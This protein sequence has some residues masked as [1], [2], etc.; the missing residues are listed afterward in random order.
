M[1]F[2]KLDKDK[3]VVPASSD[4]WCDF[5]NRFVNFTRF[6][7]G[8]EVSTVLLGIGSYLAREQFETMVFSSD[9]EIAGMTKRAGSYQEA[10]K[11]HMLVVKEIEKIS[12][13][14]YV[15]V[16]LQEIICENE[17]KREFKLNFNKRNIKI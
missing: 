7:N 8:T 5:N 4:E 1:T 12:G 17:P 3:K 11:N 16:P 9:E 10:E 2:F 6:L 14:S 15:D 13:S